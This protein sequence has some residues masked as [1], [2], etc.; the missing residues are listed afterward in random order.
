MTCLG[1]KLQSVT[2]H[3]GQNSKKAYI[4]NLIDSPH[5]PFNV[6]C[7]NTC[8]KCSLPATQHSVTKH[9]GQNSK[10]AYIYNI[11]EPRTPVQCCVWKYLPKMFLASDPTLFRVGEGV[12]VFYAEQ[13]LEMRRYVYIISLSKNLLSLIVAPF[14]SGG[15]LPELIALPKLMMPCS[16]FLFLAPI[17]PKNVGERSSM[18]S[19]NVFLTNSC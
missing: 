4:Y 1:A 14:N 10:R 17:F 15:C 2:K 3:F 13:Y 11:I 16:K 19:K 9:F 18:S 8:A 12:T 7:G 6:V 5:P